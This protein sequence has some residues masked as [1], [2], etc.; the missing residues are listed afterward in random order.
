MDRLIRA[1]VGRY[2]LSAGLWHTWDMFANA[3][4]SNNYLEAEVTFADDSRATWPFPR[5]DRLP[6]FQRYRSERYRKWVTES[7]VAA[8]NPAPVVAEAA[9]QFAAR[10][11]ERPGNPP[12]KVELIRYRSQT[13]PPRRGQLQ[14]HAE[15]PRDWERQLLYTCEFDGSGR[16]TRGY[17]ATRPS[18][19]QP[20]G[21]RP[22][23]MSP[24]ATHPVEEP[25]AREG[26]ER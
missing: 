16:M 20:S 6:Y 26:G 3:P 23:T 21:A 5:V 14:P 12:R 15:G 19:T 25:A 18:A 13:P 17:P 1:R 10:Q 4:I 11:V 9:A 2:I 22:G 24:A 8:G 7:V